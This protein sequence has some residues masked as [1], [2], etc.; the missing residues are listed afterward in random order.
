MTPELIKEHC[1]LEE[2]SMNLLKFAYEKF[3][4]SAR[5]YHKFLRLARTFADMEEEKNINK[6]HIIKALM[7]RE[8]EKEQSTMVVV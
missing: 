4:Y 7:C 2:E 3:R 8:I 1:K 5:T 6:F